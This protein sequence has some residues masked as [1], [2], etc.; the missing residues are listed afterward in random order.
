MISAGKLLAYLFV[1]VIMLTNPEYPAVAQNVAAELDSVEASKLIDF[2]K[3]KGVEV[4]VISP[5]KK[6]I[7]QQPPKDG[8]FKRIRTLRSEFRD[9]FKLL[10]SKTNGLFRDIAQKVRTVG[11][12]VQGASLSTTVLV[13]LGLILV[14]AIFWVF[15]LRWL[16]LKCQKIWPNIPRDNPEKMAF[17]LSEFMGRIA[18]IVAFSIVIYIVAHLVLQTDRITDLTIV[19]LIFTVAAIRVLVNF[20]RVWIAPDMPDHRLPAI[21]NEEASSLYRWLTVSSILTIGLIGSNTWLKEIDLPLDLLKLYAL[22]G[23]SLFFAFHVILLS[24][25][26]KVIGKTIRGDGSFSGSVTT[27]R[28]LVSKN[29]LPLSLIYLIASWLTFTIRIVLDIPHAYGLAGGMILILMASLTVYALGSV[30][31][32]KCLRP[33]VLELESGEATGNTDT[34]LVAVNQTSEGT[35]QPET[36]GPEVRTPRPSLF[37]TERFSNLSRQML[38][39]VTTCFAVGS[40][41]ILWGVNLL[42]PHS[43]ILTFWDVILLAFVGYFIYQITRVLAQTKIDQKLAVQVAG[44][45]NSNISRLA[46]L[47]PLF[48]NFVLATIVIVFSFMILARLGVNIAPLLGG[49]GVVGL[50]LGF[51]AQT[52]V[53]DIFSGA[54]FL[55]DDA[56]RNG[57]II[58]VGTVRGTVEK[59]S[60]RSMQIRAIDGSLHTIPFGDITM[61]SNYHRDWAMMKLKLR[62]TYDTDEVHVR[63]LLKKLGN[64]LKNDPDIGEL[65][66]QPMKSQGIT[67]MEDSAMIIG[68]KFKTRPGDQWLARRYVFAKIRELF[69]R[70]GIKFANREVTVRI[71]DA[72]TA[73]LDLESKHKIA[74]S[75]LPAI[76]DAAARKTGST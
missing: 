19:L 32:D 67:K 71:S 39:F 21:N 14:A 29:W 13:T 49:A 27:L 6:A 51:G 15:Y 33:P 35:I 40:V 20:W 41:L 11:G 48:R 55:A 16:R 12:N 74:G 1:T 52:L 64:E 57:E 30:L 62:L 2:A 66:L 56:F 65:F 17:L 38:S 73:D 54:F 4:L 76:E 44:D 28:G 37:R 75:V 18:G 53:R 70:E 46:T 63:K 7:E 45:T 43:V 50:A 8:I 10:R 25:K 47:L 72:D 68:V 9:E 24:A 3:K 59:I 26:R 23:S 22:V 58:N 5:G 36:V 31:I 60:I 69:Q 42:D 61:V 34:R